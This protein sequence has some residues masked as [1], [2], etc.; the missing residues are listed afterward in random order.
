MAIE[1]MS[2]SHCYCSDYMTKPTQFGDEPDLSRGKV[3][4]LTCEVGVH[5]VESGP[6]LRGE[7]ADAPWRV[8]RFSV[9]RLKVKS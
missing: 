9:E 5:N 4:N 6:M 3:A 1:M 8:S 2:I 7:W